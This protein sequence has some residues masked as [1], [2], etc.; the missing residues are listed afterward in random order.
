MK[1]GGRRGG[2]SEEE[3][4]EEGTKEK[5]GEKKGGR[6]K[7]G[8]RQRSHRRRERTGDKAIVNNREQEIWDIQQK[9]IS[10]EDMKFGRL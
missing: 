4:N 5:E 8:C 6:N 1:R 10:F 2:G 9:E 7:R 3:G